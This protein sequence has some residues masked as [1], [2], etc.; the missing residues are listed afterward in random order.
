MW[1][2][3]TRTMCPATW[4]P[5]LY[6]SLAEPPKHP[7]QDLPPKPSSEPTSSPHI[8]TAAAQYASQSPPTARLSVRAYSQCTA[9]IGSQGV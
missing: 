5:L 6:K 4:K 9:S 2:H 3:Q 8:P 1:M 7:S